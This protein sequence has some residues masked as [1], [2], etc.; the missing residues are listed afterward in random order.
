MRK[1]LRVESGSHPGRIAGD[2]G[3]LSGNPDCK[4]AVK[5]RR[6]GPAFDEFSSSLLTAERSTVLWTELQ[7]PSLASCLARYTDASDDG[8]IA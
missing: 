4:E 8:D 7:T 1:R 2:V 5:S 3:A 6:P